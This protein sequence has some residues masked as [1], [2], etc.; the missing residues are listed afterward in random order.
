MSPA[1]YIKV[2]SSDQ[3]EWWEGRSEGAPESRAMPPVPAV[4]SETGGARPAWLCS[5]AGACRCLCIALMRTWGW[6]GN[7]GQA[8]YEDSSVCH[9]CNLEVPRAGDC[10]AGS[11]FHLLGLLCLRSWLLSTRP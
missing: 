1:C 3:R 10:Q 5:M 9:P 7:L 6:L 11:G 2:G 4:S 8:T